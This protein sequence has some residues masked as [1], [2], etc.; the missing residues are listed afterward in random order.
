MAKALILEKYPL[1]INEHLFKEDW[2]DP[3]VAVSPYFGTIFKQP[4]YAAAAAKC[5]E[6]IMPFM[7]KA[8]SV[9]E[10]FGGV[11]MCSTII[12]NVLKPTQ[13]YVFDLDPRCVQ[14][15]KNLGFDAEV[16]NAHD[17]AFQPP[18][19]DIYFCEMNDFTGL[20]FVKN[21]LWLKEFESLYEQEPLALEFSD[22]TVRY[23]HAN[24]KVYTE[25]FKK[26]VVTVPDYLQC[27][28][29]FI[30]ERFGYSIA[31]AGYHSGCSYTLT[32]PGKHE[33]NSQYITDRVTGFRILTDRDN[34]Q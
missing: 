10:L 23:L 24:R 17:L 22:V 29:D 2:G 11:G 16:A 26:P 33:L 30:Y 32:L 3:N 28:S 7:P 25:L 21:G 4:S 18:P 12:E 1:E 14:H 9:V 20:R 15:L 8:D 5:I 31:A 34:I 19:A 6:Y 13:H 27:L